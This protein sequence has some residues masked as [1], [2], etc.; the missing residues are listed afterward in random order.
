MQLLAQR[1]DLIL[2]DEPESG[3]DLENIALIG[4][5]INE[6]LEKESTMRTRNFHGFDYYAHRTYPGLCEC[7]QRLHNAGW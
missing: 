2:L 6:L 5:L 4:R 3:V 1:P 7:P